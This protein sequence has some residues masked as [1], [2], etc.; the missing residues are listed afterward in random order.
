MCLSRCVLGCLSS[1]LQPIT[2][3]VI[4]NDFFP[5]MNIYDCLYSNA[6][7]SVACL[8]FTHCMYIR[9]HIH[10]LCLVYCAYCVFYTQWNLSIKDNLGPSLYYIDI[11]FHMYTYV[12]MHSICIVHILLICCVY[13][14][15]HVHTYIYSAVCTYV[16]TL[17]HNVHK[18]HKYEH[19][20][21]YDTYTTSTYTTI[22]Y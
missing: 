1:P 9:T 10:V 2:S 11:I 18:A 15:I 5:L 13:E 3:Q 16:H 17:Q 14:C 6:E 19:Y 22:L 7:V 8:Q 20:A 21:M 12:S 4:M